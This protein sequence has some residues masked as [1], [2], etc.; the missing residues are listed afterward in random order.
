MAQEYDAITVPATFDRFN[1]KADR[2]VA[3][4]FTSTVELSHDEF[5]TLDRACPASGWLMFAR[6]EFTPAD[7]PAGD[8]PDDNKKPSQRLRAV[9]HVSWKQNTDQSEPFDAYYRR[10]IEEWIESVKRDELD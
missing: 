6:N 5:S 1:R 9:L 7:I 4:H 8:A 2:S 10:R 3:L